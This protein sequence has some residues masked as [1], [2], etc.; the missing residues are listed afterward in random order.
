MTFGGS[1]ILKGCKAAFLRQLPTAVGSV[2]SCT[3]LGSLVPDVSAR[4]GAGFTPEPRLR[5]LL[6]P[7]KCRG[8]T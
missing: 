4:G 3:V 7:G 6:I 2:P 5:D 1:Q 8:Q